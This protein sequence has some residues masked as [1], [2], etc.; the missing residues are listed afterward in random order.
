[1]ISRPL[2]LFRR[3]T[4]GVYVVGVTHAGRFNA[5]T[6]AWV[7]QVS[8]DPLLLGLSVN[9][10]NFSYPMLQ[11]SGVFVINALRTGQLEV[12]RHFGTQSGRRVDKLA[13]QRWHPGALGAPILEE[14]AA[15][16]E[17]RVVGSIL[18]GDHQ[19]ILG[20]AVAGDVMA[21]TA[22]PMSYAETGDIDGSSELYPDHF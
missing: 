20:Q 8:F 15:Y 19:V 22:E 18:A 17:C 9:P 1:M 5:F 13:G 6:A 14:A 10:D 3:L 2:D 7:T 4:N 11:Q 16:L 21:D 12:A